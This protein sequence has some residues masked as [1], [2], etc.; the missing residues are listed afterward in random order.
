MTTYLENVLSTLKEKTDVV[1]KLSSFH[2]FEDINLQ[3][4]CGNHYPINWIDAI[5][6]NDLQHIFEVA[7]IKVNVYEWDNNRVEYTITLT[8]VKS[9]FTNKLDIESN[10]EAG[11]MLFALD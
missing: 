8:N 9:E 4:C 2:Q 7:D 11:K 6:H 5:N 10:R 3:D 1:V